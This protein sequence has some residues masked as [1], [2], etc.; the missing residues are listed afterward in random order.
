MV[1]YFN[2]ALSSATRSVRGNRGLINKIFLPREMFPLVSVMVSTRHFLPQVV[3]LMLV[4][5]ATGWRPSWAA[6]GYAIAGFAIVFFF[7][8][9]V[10]LIF[11]TL[12]VFFRDAE[13]VVEIVTMIAFWSAPV[14]YS[15]TFM[16]DVIGEGAL[17]TLYLSNPLVV[18]VNCF[19][20][21]FWASTVDNPIGLPDNP[22][23]VAIAL[24]IVVA[25][26][27]AGQ[28]LFARLQGRF[29]AEL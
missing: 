2:E 16:A 11:S 4:A 17:L 14:M 13:Q 18:A 21:A 24:G 3:I 20:E 1:T 26:L 19:H 22:A 8:I 15:W 9:G 12:N 25:T 28:A 10:G 29:A 23:A 27:A 5:A 7:V 6:V